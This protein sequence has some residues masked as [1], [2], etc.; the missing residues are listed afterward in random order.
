[1][2]KYLSLDV[3]L[4]DNKLIGIFVYYRNLGFILKLDYLLAFIRL[5]LVKS[6][7]VNGPL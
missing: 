6:V 5:T 7:I 3:I 4:E 2:L 1:M